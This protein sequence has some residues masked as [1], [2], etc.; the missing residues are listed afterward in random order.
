MTVDDYIRRRWPKDWP[1]QALPPLAWA[2][3]RPTYRDAQ[4]SIINAALD[5][6]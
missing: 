4:P 5:R 1:L 2:D 6:S 3:Q